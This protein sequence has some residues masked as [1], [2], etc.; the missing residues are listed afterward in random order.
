MKYF[1]KREDRINVLLIV[2]LVCIVLANLIQIYNYK[3][4]ERFTWDSGVLSKKGNI[5]QVSTCYFHHTD[6]WNYDVDKDQIIDDGWDEINYSEKSKD[7]AFYPDSL[8]ITW[9]SYTE[10]KFYKGDFKL[11]YDI[12]LEKAKYL[13]ETTTHYERTFAREN[14][15][16]I[17]LNFLAEILPNGKIVVWISDYD[18]KFKIGEYQAK[19]VNETW[20]I[21]DDYDEK[22]PD[23]KIDIGK[24]VAL[25][26]EQ[27]SYNIDLNLP[28][29]FHLTK[30]Q[31]E[32]YNQNDWNLG[33]DKNEKSYIF[34]NIPSGIH[35]SWENDTRGFASQIGFNESE[36]LDAFRE[37]DSPK[38]VKP[39][40]LELTVNEKNDSILISLKNDHKV[41]K[42]VSSYIYVHPLAQND[43]NMEEVSK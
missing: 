37:M 8:S 3:A 9:F 5:L 26:M 2:L 40:L 18:K 20:H 12:I 1:T 21:F 35:I 36:I 31:V 32:L 16:Q 17:L 28:D 38:K 4:D 23:S 13:R 41:E 19:T 27:H 30:A 42:I 10:Q 34:Q 33:D 43:K 14:P 39:L 6:A 7:N 11:P 22:N 24:K 29:G 15:N 25:V